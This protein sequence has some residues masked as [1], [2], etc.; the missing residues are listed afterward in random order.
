MKRVTVFSPAKIN[1]TL[2]ITG[3]QGGFHMLD[4]LVCT[5]DICDEVTVSPRTDYNFTAKMHGFGSEEIQPESNN[6]VHAA[7]LFSS[8]F[9]TGGAD[10]TVEK[11]IPLGAGLGGSSADAAGVLNALAALYGVRD[12][13][14][15]EEIADEVGSDTRYMLSGGWARLTERG[16]AVEKLK[17]ELKLY[18]IIL[19]PQ[20]GVS[21]AE[22]YRLYDK[23]EKEYT[24]KDGDSAVNAAVRGDFK[25]LSQ[26]IFNALYAPAKQLYSDVGLAVEEARALSAMAGMTGSGSAAFATFE[27]RAQC[28]EAYKNYN[29]K[30]SAYTA[31]TCVP[32]IVY[33]E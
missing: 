3:T 29:G 27:S 2:H 15:L 10:I 8:R 14:A 26:N 12:D 30:F 11:R 22:C 31:E 19:A 32:R 17:S 20:G 13:K 25:M 9:L 4:S 16:N 5:A 18:F 1:L 6:A 24:P 7:K 33:G 28:L 23:L 21:A